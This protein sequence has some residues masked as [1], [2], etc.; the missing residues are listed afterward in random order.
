LDC[1]PY[2]FW[3]PSNNLPP[4]SVALAPSLAK[5]FNSAKN[6]WFWDFNLPSYAASD[7]SNR[8]PHVVLSDAGIELVTPNHTGL[9]EVAAYKP[10]TY[11]VIVLK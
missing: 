2:I 3:P 10:T 8:K 4:S 7:T 11:R 9:I 5:K 1:A 6:R